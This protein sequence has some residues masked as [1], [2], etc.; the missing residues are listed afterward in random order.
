MTDTATPAQLFDLT[1]RTAL[2]T[3]ASSG[4]GVTFARTLAAAGANVVLAARRTDRL[5][6]LAAELT[7]AGPGAAL[8]VT[9][10]VTD[11]DQNE[12]AVAAAVERF[13]GLDIAVANAGAVLEGFSLPERMP[14]AM[15]AGSIDVNLSGT[16]YTCQSAGRHMLS[17]GGGSII[18]ISSYTGMAGVPNFPPAYQ[19]A[20]AAT[21]NIT[22][23]LAASWGDRG[24]R[25][26]AIC[27]GWFPSEMT[28]AVL[29][30]P[31]WNDRITS[32]APM[33]RTGDPAELA[34]PLLLLASDASSYMTGSVTAVDGGTSAVVGT[35]PYTPELFGLHQAVMGD[36]GAPITP[37]V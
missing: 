6:A 29:A 8:A 1:G 3:G 11:P 34:G 30:A 10:D 12:A 21:I 33:G 2:V 23:S 5:E 13:G 15:W 31:I 35:D 20:K 24:V 28:D 36:L 17:R 22:Q 25:V 9:C 32:H 37:E 19:A 27:P 4:L 16:W 18:V 26:N 14:P 7:A